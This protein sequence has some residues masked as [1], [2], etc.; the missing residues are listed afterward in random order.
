MFNPYLAMALHSICQP[1]RPFPNG[2]SQNGSPGFAAFHRAKS[3]ISR[4][5]SLP[6]IKLVLNLSQLNG[7]SQL[8]CNV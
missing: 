7:L 4:F 1:G 6:I 5:S 8:F 2:D 3:L